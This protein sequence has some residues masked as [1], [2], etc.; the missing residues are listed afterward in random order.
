MHANALRTVVFPL[1]LA[2]LTA[3]FAGC[4]SRAS[5]VCDLICECEHCNDYE[6]DVQCEAI[7]TT[8]EMAAVYECA[9]QWEAWATCLEERGRCEETEANFTTATAGSC[10]GKTNTNFPCM[11]NGDC[12]STFGPA[13]LCESG[14]CSQRTCA[15]SDIPCESNNQCSGED[16]CDA[17][18]DAL[19]DCV[20]NASSHGGVPFDID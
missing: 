1:G 17:E 6:E 9:D 13:S 20:D 18:E 3:F 11:N 5:A 10:S 14:M 12:Q 2:A 19:D 4:G 8:A 15:G 16:Q 7:E